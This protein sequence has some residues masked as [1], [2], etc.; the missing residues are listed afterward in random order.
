[1]WSNAY[2][3][4]LY[5]VGVLSFLI[6]VIALAIPLIPTVPFLL[7]S[8]YCFS[9]SSPRFRSWLINHKHF[10][11]PIIEW[12]THQVIRPQAK[13]IATLCLSISLCIPVFILDIPAWG[14]AGALIAGSAVI[15]FIL[16]R[17]SKIPS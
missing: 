13:A 6:G 4:F 15:A 7:L 1:M 14:K 5:S 2:R 9:K 12:E 8:A 16:S 11:P 10:G 3:W 17:N